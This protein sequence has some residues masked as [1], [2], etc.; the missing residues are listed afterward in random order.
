MLPLFEMKCHHW[1]LPL[2]E[3]NVYQVVMLPLVERYCHQRMLPLVERN[4]Y[5]GIPLVESGYYSLPIVES[6]NQGQMG[7]SKHVCLPTVE[8][9][10]WKVLHV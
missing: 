1:M 9:D 7:P 2:F 3:R 10:E 4:L 8:R 6:G 5:Q